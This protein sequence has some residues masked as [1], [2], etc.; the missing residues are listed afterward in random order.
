[1]VGTRPVAVITEV[2]Q[3]R[4]CVSLLIVLL[5]IS[6][7]AQDRIEGLIEIPA[8]HSRVNSGVRDSA[9]GPVPLYAAPNDVSEVAV[10]VR[11][12]RELESREHD[13]EQVSAV[14][15]S[16]QGNS[17]GGFWY[18]VR[19]IGEG[20]PIFGWL[21]QSNASTFR[22]L[23]TLVESNRAYLTEDWDGLLY[24]SPTQSSPAEQ[25]SIRARNQSVRVI[26]SCQRSDQPLWFLVAIV[27][28]NCSAGPI[29][30]IET[31]WVRAYSESGS[32]NVW[33]ASRGC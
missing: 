15:Y 19:Y 18:R 24:E 21:N 31:G 25:T 6:T 7:G 26:D 29:E 3:I 10:I 13:Y 30:V 23:G 27:R 22:G 11:D 12:R 33:F 2:I 17:G 8:L 1:M 16:R 32:T 28:G 9:T 20:G 5:P 14:V 4:R